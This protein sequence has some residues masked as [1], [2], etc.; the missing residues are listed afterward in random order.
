MRQWKLLGIPGKALLSDTREKIQLASTF[1]FSCP[2]C[3]HKR[4]QAQI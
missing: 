2:E 1:P 3:E 4:Q